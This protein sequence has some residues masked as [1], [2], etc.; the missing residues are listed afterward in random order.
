MEISHACISYATSGAAPRHLRWHRVQHVK[1]TVRKQNLNPLDTTGN[2]PKA[3]RARRRR[4]RHRHD[5]EFAALT[6]VRRPD[7]AYATHKV[8]I[9]T[10]LAQAIGSETILSKCA[11]RRR[12]HRQTILV[13]GATRATKRIVQPF[14]TLG[15]REGC[16]RRNVDDDVKRCT[17][18]GCERHGVASRVSRRVADNGMGGAMRNNLIRAKFPHVLIFVQKYCTRDP[19]DND[20]TRL[21]F[22]PSDTHPNVPHATTNVPHATTN[23]VFSPTRA[24]GGE[25]SAAHA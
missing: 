4:H 22:S 17:R 16:V 15:E 5:G 10:E 6:R 23:E 2:P 13:G 20:G 19:V 11:P 24:V 25:V 12:L 8:R 9:G 7:G 3:P 18:I 21:P 1:S 14:R